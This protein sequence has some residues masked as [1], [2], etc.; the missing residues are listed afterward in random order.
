[1]DAEPVPSSFPP[2]GRIVW[3]KLNPTDPPCHHLNEVFS[4]LGMGSSGQIRILD[5]ETGEPIGGIA[6]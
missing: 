1:M 4:L 6:T 5:E 3:C 2:C